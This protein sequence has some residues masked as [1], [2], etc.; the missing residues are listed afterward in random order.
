MR[1]MLANCA[2]LFRARSILEACIAMG[3]R[4]DDTAVVNAAQVLP[5]KNDYCRLS[6][7]P[8]AV[9]SAGAANPLAILID[10]LRKP[11]PAE[12]SAAIC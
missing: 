4:E 9:N 5:D 7:R 8:L 12:H 11:L 1:N 6:G 2:R 10:N 3:M